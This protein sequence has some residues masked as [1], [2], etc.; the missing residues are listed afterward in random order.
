MLRSFEPNEMRAS[1]HQ[2]M[3]PNASRA[4]ARDVVVRAVEQGSHLLT[5]PKDRV[6]V[7]MQVGLA[8]L[9]RLGFS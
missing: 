6:Q 1:M 3:K 2:A 4:A 8:V 7:I 5:A 9:V